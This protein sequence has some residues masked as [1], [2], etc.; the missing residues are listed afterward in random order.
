MV[1]ELIL[2]KEQLRN[3]LAK[4]FNVE[5][6]RIGIS[7]DLRAVIAAARTLAS[8]EEEMALIEAG[9]IASLKNALDYMDIFENG[10][11]GKDV[12]MA[13]GEDNVRRAV[14]DALDFFNDL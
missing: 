9:A 7:N 6:S 14:G 11:P 12:S 10:P 13:V 2:I 4:P 8:S 1:E 5:Q 3:L